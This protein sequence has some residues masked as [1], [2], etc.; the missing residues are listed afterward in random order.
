MDI[1]GMNRVCSILVTRY[2]L[3]N[4]FIWALICITA[5]LRLVDWHFIR[6][7]LRFCCR[8]QSSKSCC[9]WCGRTLSLESMDRNL[10]LP[11]KY[12]FNGALYLDSSWFFQ[13]FPAGLNEQHFKV[14]HFSLEVLIAHQ[15][16]C[17]RKVNQR[18]ARLSCEST[19][20][21]GRYGSGYI[22]RLRVSPANLGVIPQAGSPLYFCIC[23]F[24]RLV[25]CTSGLGSR[26]AFTSFDSHFEV[27]VYPHQSSLVRGEMLGESCA[28]C[29][30]AMRSI[31][32]SIARWGKHWE[33]LELSDCSTKEE[34]KVLHRNKHP[35]PIENICETW[36]V[37]EFSPVVM[38]KTEP[39]FR[40][41]G[42]IARASVSKLWEEEHVAPWNCWTSNMSRGNLRSTSPCNTRRLKRA[43]HNICLH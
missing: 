40:W 42:S 35:G 41:I 24:P 36:K 21:M 12:L 13:T 38:W 9:S 1:C 7:A 31:S 28:Q 8:R 25:A 27:G 34:I 4:N 15:R 14:E 18:S 29:D 6:S 17:C 32:P 3:V 11:L 20:F 16:A 39:L 43:A 26:F 30:E 23:N 22:T 2:A 5:P 37:C 33:A 19:V 10:H